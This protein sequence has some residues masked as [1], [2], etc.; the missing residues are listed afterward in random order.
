MAALGAPWPAAVGVSGGSDSLALMLLLRDWAKR[1]GRKPPAV[2][3]VDHGLRPE[4][5]EEARKVRLWARKAGLTA[6]VLTHK[7]KI[8]HA[9][10]EAAARQLRYRLLGEWAMRSGCAAVY[11]AHTQDDQAETF[12]LRLARGSGLDGLSAMRPLASYPDPGFPALKLVRPLLGCTRQSLRAFL[13]EAGQPWLDDPMNLDPRFARVRIRTAWPDLEALGLTRARLA[14]AA[15]HLGRARQA[16]EAVSQVLLQRGCTPYKGGLLLDSA[17]LSDT[18]QE[19]GLR[20]LAEVLMAVSKNPYRP[21]FERLTGLFSAILGGSLG[22]GR[23]LHGCRV[24]PAPKAGQA[25]GP[26]TLLVQPEKSRRK[27]GK[28]TGRQSKR[29]LIP[30]SHNRC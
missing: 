3:C 17:I 28:K 27:A 10:I 12:L 21:R 23:T 24:A 15:H 6:H 16:L 13:E 1:S 20:A 25:F 22:A 9:D 19:L 29:I 18:P 30:W 11:V 8:P 4:A 5:G 14:E 7:G 26:G 2:L